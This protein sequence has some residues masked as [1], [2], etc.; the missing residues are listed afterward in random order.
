MFCIAAWCFPLLLWAFV[1]RVKRRLCIRIERLNLS[2]WLVQILSVSGLPKRR[3]FF[4]GVTA[5][6]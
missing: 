5:A 4:A 6:S 1:R 3:L 2:I